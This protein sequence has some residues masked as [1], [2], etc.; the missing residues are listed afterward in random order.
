[1]RRCPSTDTREVPCHRTADVIR[2]AAEPHGRTGGRAVVIGGSLTGM[3]AAAALSTTMAEV[4]VVERH[5]LPGGPEPR[6]GV[7]QARH[8]HLLW[9]G[10]ARAVEQMLPGVTERLLGAGARRIAVPADLVMMTSGGWLTRFPE[11]QFFLACSRDLIDWAVRDL[12]TAHPSVRTL[13]GATVLGLRG[14]SA[15]VSG[16]AVRTQQGDQVLDADL[17]V[18]MRR[19]GLRHPAVAGGPR[20]AAGTHPGGRRRARV[21]HQALPRPGRAPRRSPPSTSRPTPA[22]RSPG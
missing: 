20:A 1:M 17:V 9:S 10:G 8:A 19:P 13:P 4:T 3:L 21:R 6:Q 14:T 22:C 11:H 12:A 2:P 7:P 18:D 15:R 16:V 5:E